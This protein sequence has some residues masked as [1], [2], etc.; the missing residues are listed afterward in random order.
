MKNILILLIV[1][2]MA[3]TVYAQERHV[4]QKGISI[5]TIHLFDPIGYAGVSYEN[6][7]LPYDSLARLY[8]KCFKKNISLK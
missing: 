7:V 1:A 4:F 3:N 2:S 8:L 6:N 5:D